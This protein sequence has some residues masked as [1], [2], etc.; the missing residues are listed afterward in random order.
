[1]H[2]GI[3]FGQIFSRF[4]AR[5]RK[6]YRSKFQKCCPTK[7]TKVKKKFSFPVIKKARFQQKTCLK[8]LRQHFISFLLVSRLISIMAGKLSQ[9]MAV[10]SLINRRDGVVVRASAS[11]SVDMGF[12]TLAESYRKTFKYGI[13]SFRA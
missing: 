13:Y 1:M 8:K 12:I 7:I 6:S 9:H 5:P 3:W 4:H 11:Q 10:S 2:R